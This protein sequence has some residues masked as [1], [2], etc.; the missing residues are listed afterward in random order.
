M[1]D[2]DRI[3]AV[4]RG[5]ASNQ[6]GP[7]SGL[8]A[9]NGPAQEALIREAL[10]DAGVAPADVAYV[11]TH[12]TGT[13]LGDPIEAQAL[14]AALAAGR[15]ES[16]RVRIGSVKTNVGHLEA[17]AGVTSLIK[18]VL[19]LQHRQI[20]PH[21][22]FTTPSPHIDWD[23][24][25]LE[26]PTTLEPWTR[27][28]PGAGRRQFVRL[29]RHQR[30]PRG[31]GGARRAGRSRGPRLATNGPCMSLPLSARTETALEQRLRDLRRVPCGDARRLAARRVP[32]AQ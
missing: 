28:S 2:G 4:I 1:A 14:G 21:L 27:G 20:P 24:L 13:A 15:D 23:A 8:T 18:V 9:P 16:S 17:A 7:S 32:H 25:P 19:A 29:Q 12:G 30:A 5:T 26:V 11:E 10:A 31:R 22:N 6:D 3:L